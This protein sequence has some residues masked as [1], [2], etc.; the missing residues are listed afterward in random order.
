MAALHRL[1]WI[2]AEIRAARYPNARRLAE[3]FEISHRQA[4][5]DFEYLRDSLGAPLAYSAQRRGY[6]YDGEAYVLPGQ[7]VTPLQRGLLGSLAEYYAGS[8]ERRDNPVL[9]GMAALFARL[10]GRPQGTYRRPTDASPSPGAGL[11]LPF[12]ARLSLSGPDRQP[13]ATGLAGPLPGALAPFYRGDAG[14]NRI[15]CELHDA[16]AF[17]AAVLGAGPPFRVEHP[18]W[19]RDRLTARLDALRAANAVG[20]GAAA[21]PRP[22][23]GATRCVVPDR[24]A[25]GH[26]EIAERSETMAAV[27]TGARLQM[28][29]TTFVGAAEGVLKAAGLVDPRLDTSQLMGLTGRAFHLTMDDSCWPGC[30]TMYDWAREHAAAFE[31]VGVLAELFLAMPDSPTFDAA[32]RRA[33]TNIKASLDRGAA[34]VLWG[35]DVPEFGVVHGYDDADGVFLV[36]GVARLNGGSSTPIL[37]ENVGRSC[38]V[39]ELHYVVPIE[40]VPWDEA[41]AHR[42][43]LRDYV[44]RT[45]TRPQLVPKYPSGLRAYDNWIRALEAGTFDQ[46]GLRYNTAV[47]ADARKHA[48]I[49]LERLAA[50]GLG[51][52]H[53]PE[54]AAA[55][56]ENAALYAGMVDVL[57]PAGARPS[58]HLGQP[59]TP[60]QARALVPLVREAGGLEARQ[61]DFTK[62]ALAG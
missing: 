4:Q 22:D 55:A 52:P 39:P 62:R 23:A 46:F 2:D 17:L 33:V 50:D 34:V 20:A 1:Q 42:A 19:L 35:V 13:G 32:R 44:E 27:R 30:P 60:E 26:P 53:L 57:W 3:H 14:P 54:V 24:V 37:Y 49:Y 7:F 12:L 6:R 48:A 56:R 38:E 45:E 18:A 29:W 25:S 36:D 16:D 59:V 40:R 9:D 51:L 15:T 58:E 11:R 5:R 31:R 47:L 21:E 28:S 10:S 61:L 8:A 41:A 43:A